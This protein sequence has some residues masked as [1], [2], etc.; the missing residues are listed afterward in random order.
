MA[1]LVL[2]VRVKRVGPRFVVSLLVRGD[3][4]LGP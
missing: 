2:S 1:P 4:D 3:L